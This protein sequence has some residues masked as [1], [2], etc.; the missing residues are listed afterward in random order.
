MEGGV[1]M[2]VGRLAENGREG[3][4]FGFVKLGL[5]GMG[6]RGAGGVVG[7]LGLTGFEK[8]ECR[9]VRRVV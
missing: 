9:V 4:E 1:G 3:W 2:G 7:G 5:S 8:R 6:K